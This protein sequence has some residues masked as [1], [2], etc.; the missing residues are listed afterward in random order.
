MLVLVLC[1]CS[2]GSHRTGSAQET[3]D[4]DFGLDPD[5][6]IRIADPCGS[7][8]IRGSDSPG[9]RLRTIKKAGSSEQLKNIGVTIAAQHDDFA[10]KTTL[11]R[12]K[13]KPFFGSGESVDYELSVPRTVKIQRLEVDDGDVMLEG[14]ESEDVR[15]NIVDGRL[16]VK[17]CHGNLRLAIQNG[18]LEMIYDRPETLK[19]TIA[20][21]MLTGNARLSI[22]G[23]TAFHVSAETP[24]GN[25]TNNLSASVQVNGGPLRKVDFSCGNPP[26]SE[27]QLRVMQGN[28]SIV[29]APTGTGTVASIPGG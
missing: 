6:V 28:V 16:T 9:L 12:N 17:N 15:A 27:I 20:A 25:I 18:T 8:S 24:G 29:G 5:A 14:L 4:Q 23:N 22:A 19:S 21:R 7:I 1:V 13:K 11:V 3:T 2:C 10:I 26:R